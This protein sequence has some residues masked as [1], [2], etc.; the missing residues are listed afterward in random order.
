MPGSIATILL[1]LTVAAP[2]TAQ[3]TRLKAHH[4]LPPVAPGH[5]MMLAPWVEKVEADSDGRLQIDIYPSMHLG[6]Q[7]PRAH[8]SG[9]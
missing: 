6:G 7:A 2:L 3:E 4:M 9:L 8:R 5:A 1:A